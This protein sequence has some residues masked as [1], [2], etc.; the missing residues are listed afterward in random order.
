MKTTERSQV[1]LAREEPLKLLENK[2]AHVE[3]ATSKAKGD[4]LRRRCSLRPENADSLA[5]AAMMK[6]PA[7]PVVDE[8]V[9]R[10]GAE[11][12]RRGSRRPRTDVIWASR[13]RRG[14]GPTSFGRRGGAL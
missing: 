11:E 13:R 1:D 9:A 14:R 2:I 12:G 10:R 7:A 3:Q 8:P 5:D 4:E 6:C